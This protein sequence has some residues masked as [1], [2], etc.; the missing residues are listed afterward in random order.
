MVPMTVTTIAPMAN[1]TVDPTDIIRTPKEAG[2]HGSAASG[3]PAAVL[4]TT[5]AT[6]TARRSGRRASSNTTTAIGASRRIV[7]TGCDLARTL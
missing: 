4:L 5:A 7:P 2:S 1:S 6:R 3:S